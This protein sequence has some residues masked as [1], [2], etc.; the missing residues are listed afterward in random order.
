MKPIRLRRYLDKKSFRRF[1]ALARK[2]ANYDRDRRLWVPAADKILSLSSRD[3]EVVLSELSRYAHVDVD[4]ILDFRRRAA[5]VVILDGNLGLRSADLGVEVLRELLAGLAYPRGEVLKLRSVIYV[6]AAARILAQRGY[7]VMFDDSLLRVK[8]ERRRGR[9]LVHAPR[10]DRELFRV[11][12]EACTLQYFVE[13]PILGPGGEYMGSEVVSRR[14]KAFEV[15]GDRGVFI[16]YVGLIEDVARALEK[17]GLRPVIEIAGRDKMEIPIRPS[18]ALLPHQEEAYKLWRKKRRG[19]IAIFTRGGKSFIALKAISDMRVP[20]VIFVPTR[21]LVYTWRSYL[22]KYLGIPGSLVGVVGGGRVD[23]RD[24]TLAIY[25]SGVRYIEKLM[26]V[27]ELAVFDEAHHVPAATFK[28]VALGIDSLYRMALSATPKRRDG[29]EKLLFKLSGE[30]VFNLGYEDLLKLRIVAPLEV[31]DTVFVEGEGEKL[32]KLYQVVRRYEKSKT[33]IFT[34]YLSTAS[35]IHEEL[36]R[37]GINA[38][39]ITGD[40]PE[41]RRSLAFRSFLEGK[42]RV[43]VTTTVL[44]EGITVPDA[45][46]AIVY[47][48]TGEGRQMIQR[49]GRVIGYRPG[50]TAK[51]FEIIDVTNPREKYAYLRRKW[52]KDLYM[53]RDIEKYVEMEKRGERTREAYQLRMDVFYD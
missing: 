23:V 22:E 24:I 37:R 44:D 17:N 7:R 40:T 26:G 21:E 6:G 1:L 27:F 41:G 31:Y 34:Q 42:T 45:E 52:V 12:R 30:L 18:F 47:E 48:G 53:V 9:L 38:V 5:G 10:P 15:D 25:N 43:V 50:K 16:T 11:L 51:V 19:T 49:I 13:K 35:Q 29:N 33:I 3:L 36:V 20:T 28:E 32:E 4:G 14:I 2:V 46:V 8:I 39:L